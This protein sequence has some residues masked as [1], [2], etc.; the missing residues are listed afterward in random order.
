MLNTQRNTDKDM[1]TQT[2]PT[3]KIRPGLTMDK[4]KIIAPK[5][6]EAPIGDDTFRLIKLDYYRQ[7]W[8]GR[9]GRPKLLRATE[10]K[11]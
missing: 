9:L 8:D 5:K 2:T 7:I 11:V 4:M 10:P 1:A 3:V 6:K